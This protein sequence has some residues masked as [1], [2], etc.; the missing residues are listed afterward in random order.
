MPKKKKDK[1]LKKIIK[2]KKV[3]THGGRAGFLAGDV[4]EDGIFSSD[5]VGHTVA[6]ISNLLKQ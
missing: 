4:E 3:Q 5:D 1:N 6:I 2:K